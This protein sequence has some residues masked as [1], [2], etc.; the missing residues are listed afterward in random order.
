MLLGTS[1]YGNYAKVTTSLNIDIA[2]ITYAQSLLEQPQSNDEGILDGVYI[3][4]EE[5][6]LPGGSKESDLRSL[7]QCMNVGI[8]GTPEELDCVS[9]YPQLVEMGVKYINTDFG[10]K[11]L[12]T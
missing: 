9:T 6:M 3:E 4:F 2:D 8:W 10:P 12:E 1:P 5:A 7:C 11:F